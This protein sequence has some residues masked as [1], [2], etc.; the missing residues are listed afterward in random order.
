MSD[1]PGDVILGDFWDRDA[2]C[3]FPG[4]PVMTPA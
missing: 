1:D 2:A 4:K 3:N